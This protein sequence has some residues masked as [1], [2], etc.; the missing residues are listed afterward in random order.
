[1]NCD[2]MQHV[3]NTDIDEHV[4]LIYVYFHARTTGSLLE[5]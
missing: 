1:M 4:E 3:L 5:I 2:F